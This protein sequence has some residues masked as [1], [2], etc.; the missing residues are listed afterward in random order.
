MCLKESWNWTDERVLLCTLLFTHD[1]LIRLRAY[2]DILISCL[3]NIS[4]IL[5]FML[6]Y[7]ITSYVYHDV[8]KAYSIIF[9]CLIQLV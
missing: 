2:Y 6:C 8:L 4:I 5:C 3:F 9:F 1:T 7:T